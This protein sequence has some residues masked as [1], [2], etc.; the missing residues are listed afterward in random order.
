[1]CNQPP[2]CYR[3]GSSAGLRAGIAKKL[4]NFIRQIPPFPLE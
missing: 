4:N 1:M 3:Y 2:D